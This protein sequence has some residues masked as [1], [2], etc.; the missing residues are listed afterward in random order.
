MTETQS[1]RDPSMLASRVDQDIHIVRAGGYMLCIITVWE[2]TGSAI[3]V[4][5][6][7]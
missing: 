6:G 3:A 1:V 4:T 7:R 2:I 5:F